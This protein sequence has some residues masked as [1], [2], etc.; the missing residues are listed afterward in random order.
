MRTVHAAIVIVSMVLGASAAN[1]QTATPGAKWPDHPLRFIVPLPAGSAADVMAR[2]IGQ[3]LSERI[4]QPIIA[5]NRA[6]ASGILGSDVVAKGAPD[7]Y[8]LGIATSTTHVTAPIFNAKMP[9]DPI[10]DFA[11]VALV[12]ISPYVLVVSPTLPVKTV[13]DVVARAKAKPRTLSYSSVGQAS[14]AYLAMELFSAKTG[15]EFNHI[16][17]KSSTHAV[18]DL[19]EGRIDMQ[20][21]ILGTSLELIKEGK[22]RALALATGKRSADLPEVPTTAEAGVKDFEASLL[23]A[24]MMPPKT[25][26]EIV[27]RINRDIVEIMAEPEVKRALAGQ[28]IIATSSTPDELR[29]RMR[30]EIE[31]WRGL[32]VK[33][34]LVAEAGRGN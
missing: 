4:G 11:P 7:G 12:G 17:Y 24:V 25:P 8:M 1:A 2:L 30:N 6:G 33:A 9:F 15:A 14:Q 32:A 21:G 22:L 19:V 29:D 26:A 27:T 16:P 23:F 5:E 20:F 28:A 10:N 31:L 34:G 3:K 13:A 18:I